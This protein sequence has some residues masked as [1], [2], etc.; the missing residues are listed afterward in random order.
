MVRNRK[1]SYLELK[2]GP[3]RPPLYDLG[4]GS[5]WKRSTWPTIRLC[6]LTRQEMAA[7]LKAGW[8]AAVL[9]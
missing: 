1:Y 2:K 3:V 9:P 6:A 8:K 4:E 5:A 7:L